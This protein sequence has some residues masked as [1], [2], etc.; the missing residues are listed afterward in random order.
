M[1]I[2]PGSLATLPPSRLSAGLKTAPYSSF[3]KPVLFT[4]LALSPPS[5]YISIIPPGFLLLPG[6]QN[7]PDHRRRAVDQDP[8]FTRQTPPTPPT[9]GLG[10]GSPLSPAAWPL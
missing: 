10:G 3:I 1:G 2:K 8:V 9:K 4:A 7:L 6:N 5:S